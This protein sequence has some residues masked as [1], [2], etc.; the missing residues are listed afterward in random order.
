MKNFW[1]FSRNSK[2]FSIAIWITFK[3]LLKNLMIAKCWRRLHFDKKSCKYKMKMWRI[4]T[5][6][7]FRKDGIRYKKWEKIKNL[8]FFVHNNIL[9]FNSLTIAWMYANRWNGNKAFVN[10]FSLNFL[11]N[12][13]FRT[14]YINASFIKLLFHLS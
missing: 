2:R 4:R 6:S 7:A 14:A 3:T 1:Y 9:D 10:H 11:Q 13:W 5:H 8:L 12:K